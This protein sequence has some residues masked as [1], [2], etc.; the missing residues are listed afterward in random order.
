MR[1]KAGFSVS[2]ECVQPTP[3]LLCLSVHPSRLT[4]LLSPQELRFTPEVAAWDYIDGFGN[5]CT[6][7]VAP[8]GRTTISTSFEISDTGRPDFLPTTAV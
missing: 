7:I 8:T 5:T 3:M 4:D 2:Y 1:I 6:R